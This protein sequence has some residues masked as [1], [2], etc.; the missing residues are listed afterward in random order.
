MPVLAYDNLSFWR[1]PRIVKQSGV[2]HLTFELS[3]LREP[4][5]FSALCSAHYLPRARLR[6]S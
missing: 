1:V 2:L 3:R 5:K 4:P 6:R